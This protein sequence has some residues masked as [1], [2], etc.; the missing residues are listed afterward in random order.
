MYKQHRDINKVVGNIGAN[1]DK[2]SRQWDSFDRLGL[3]NFVFLKKEIF[4]P[5]YQN[6]T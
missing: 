1:I 5:T 2:M 6:R 4:T 3:I